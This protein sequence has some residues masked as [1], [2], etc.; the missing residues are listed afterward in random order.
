MLNLDVIQNIDHNRLKLNAFA[1]GRIQNRLV[2]SYDILSE[3]GFKY[4]IHNSLLT[5]NVMESA[6]K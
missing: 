4:P 5:I 3:Y 6:K 2:N 1:W